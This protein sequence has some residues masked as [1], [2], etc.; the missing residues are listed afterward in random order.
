[1]RRR[2]LYHLGKTVQNHHEQTANLN[3]QSQS[4]AFQLFTISFKG[5]GFSLS[6][7][8]C[9]QC[10]TRVILQ[11]K[12]GVSSAKDWLMKQILF[13]TAPGETMKR[14][15]FFSVYVGI[16]RTMFGTVLEVV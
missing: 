9:I 8:I 2:H 7:S 5:F 6:L 16:K 12:I 4:H 15:L 14:Q 10:A 3:L 1:M 13:K 11:L